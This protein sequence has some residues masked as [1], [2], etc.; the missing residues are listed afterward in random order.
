MTVLD[1][2][3][4]RARGGWLAVVVMGAVVLGAVPFYAGVLAGPA[5]D[6]VC[7]G[8]GCLSPGPD[9]LSR[10]AGGEPA[11]LGLY[12][13][14]AVPTAYLILAGWFTARARRTGL[15]QRWGV[16]VAAG[17]VGFAVL[18]ASVLPA[19]DLVSYSW[20][21]VAWPLL[22]VAMSLA[23]LGRVE[24][25]RRLDVIALAAAAVAVYVGVFKTRP[26]VL[27]DGWPAE[28]LFSAAC[29]PQG[30]LALLGAAM[31]ACGGAW[32]AKAR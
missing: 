14:V 24:R 9:H 16:Y 8:T 2:L 3:R 25:D 32:S 12:W 30:S 15:Q 28:P 23:V 7:G 1:E 13:L 21:A 19:A 17:L 4:R 5:R 31:L 6:E 22:T 11:A 27:S 26:F 18:V 10:L 29:S 20:R